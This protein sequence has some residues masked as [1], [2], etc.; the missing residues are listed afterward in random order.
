MTQPTRTTW[1]IPADVMLLTD[2]AD[3]TDREVVMANAVIETIVG[4]VYTLAYE[5][6]GA[7]D[8]EWLRRAVAYQV[9]WMRAQPDFFERLDLSTLEG[10]GALGDLTLVCPPMGRHAIRRL[11]WRGSRSQRTRSPYVNRAGLPST[12][13]LAEVNDSYE[14]WT[15]LGGR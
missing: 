2:A 15:P 10:A 14:Q 13:P 4:R 7:A 6:T 8:R 1:A 9:P 12:N 11:S 3:V 5:R